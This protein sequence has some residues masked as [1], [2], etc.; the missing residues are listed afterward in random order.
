MFRRPPE[1]PSILAA[2][3][4]AQRESAAAEVERARL[5]AQ[6]DREQQEAAAEHARRQAI[7][8]EQERRRRDAARR[9]ERAERRERQRKARAEFAAKLRP[10]LP[11]LLINGGA[12]YAQ[13]AYA[14]N[15]IAPADWN[16]TSRVAFAIAF[17]AALESIAVYVQWHAHD[18]LLLKAHATAASLR[19]AAWVIAAVVAAI[20]YAHFADGIAPTAAAVAFALLSLLSPWLWGLHT[21]RAQHVQLLAEDAD[22]ID[23]AGVE[24]SPKRRRMFPIRS[25][26]AARW[27]IEHNERDPRKAWDGYHTERAARTAARKANQAQKVTTP[28][29]DPTPDEMPAD[30]WDHAEPVIPTP[31]VPAR[32][33][34]HPARVTARSLTAAER[35][36]DAHTTEPTANH[37]RI[38]RLAQV[39]VSTVKRHRPRPVTGSPSAPDAAATPVAATPAPI[40]A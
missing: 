32:K 34:V 31:H 30:P 3:A 4:A 2:R 22:L 10:V 26:M 15:Q 38:A 7:A 25:L 20:N 27:S 28:P 1:D 12:A 29:V 14:Y 13:A 17:A 24:F 11:L 18:A 23:D 37:E 33:P 16:T 9:V 6:L 5:M 36:I 8:D 19:R 21:R 39:S 40:A 35:V